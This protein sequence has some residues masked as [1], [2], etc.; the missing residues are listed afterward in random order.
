[1]NA[2]QIY[3]F[4]RNNVE[5]WQVGVALL[6]LAAG[7]WAIRLLRFAVSFRLLALGAGGAILYP[8]IKSLIPSDITQEQILPWEIG[9]GLLMAIA[10]SI[11]PS[12]QPQQLS[13][14]AQ[15]VMAA[16]DRLTHSDIMI[17]NSGVA[18]IRTNKLKQE[19]W[20]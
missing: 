18:E 13:P 19:I 9:A 6:A 20:P 10:W 3:D 5:P 12:K 2:D 11:R 15:K 4:V 7:K 1:M 8:Y 14:E 17:N 16:F